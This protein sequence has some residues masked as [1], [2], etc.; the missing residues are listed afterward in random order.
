MSKKLIV[1]KKPLSLKALKAYADKTGFISVNIAVSLEEI[2]TDI[3]SLN[4]L[5]DERIL[6]LDTIG[7]SLSDISY[8]VVGFILPAK[9]NCIGY[10]KGQ[11]ILNVTADVSEI[12]A[13]D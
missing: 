11:I 1:L 4:D 12:T 10:L 6:D 3:E 9:E 2:M 5:A 7:G 8:E 13:M